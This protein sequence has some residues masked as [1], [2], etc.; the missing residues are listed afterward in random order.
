MN[1]KIM[2]AIKNQSAIIK[3]LTQTNTTKKV[4]ITL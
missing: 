1:L 4:G 2:L 3:L